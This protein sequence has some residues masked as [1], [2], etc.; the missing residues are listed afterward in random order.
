MWQD[1]GIHPTQ[2]GTYLAACVFY[3]SIF[4]QSPEGLSFHG[5]VSDAQ[6]QVLQAEAGQHVL[7]LSAEWGL[8]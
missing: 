6:A 5:G 8:R 1:D 2:A 7:D 4:R 3:A